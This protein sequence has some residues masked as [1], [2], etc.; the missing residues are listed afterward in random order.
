MSNTLPH[1]LSTFV[2]NSDS[3]QGTDV[4]LRS[5]RHC[6]FAVGHLTKSKFKFGS[7]TS[8]SL[9]LLSPVSCLSAICESESVPTSVLVSACCI[10]MSVPHCTG[11]CSI[12][13]ELYRQHPLGMEGEALQ[14]SLTEFHK[15]FSHWLPLIPTYPDSKFHRLSANIHKWLPSTLHGKFQEVAFSVCVCCFQHMVFTH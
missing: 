3:Q 5:E 11:P 10:C 13:I 8:C 15:G 2:M 6:P 4:E 7:F 12:F 14:K 1:G 9:C